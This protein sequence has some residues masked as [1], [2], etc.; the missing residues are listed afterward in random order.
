MKKL[1]KNQLKTI[2]KNHDFPYS[3]TKKELYKRILNAKIKPS[4]ALNQLTRTDLKQVLKDLEGVKSLCE[5]TNIEDSWS[6]TS[7]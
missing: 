4:V 3:G 5:S 7:I 1:K 6:S 2:L